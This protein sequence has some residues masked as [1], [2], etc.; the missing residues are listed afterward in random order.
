M[1][2]LKIIFFIWFAGGFVSI[3]LILIKLALRWLNRFL[4]GE[5]YYLHNLKK[6]HLYQ[7]PYDGKISHTQHDWTSYLIILGM[8]FL[9]SWIDVI[10]HLYQIAILLITPIKTLF[11]S[12]PPKFKEIRFSLWNVPDLSPELVW[13]KV[14]ALSMVATGIKPKANQVIEDLNKFYDE[15][16]D[17]DRI[18]AF[19]ALN[20]TIELKEETIKECREYLEKEKQLDMEDEESLAR[21]QNNSEENNIYAVK[22]S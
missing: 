19:E 8:E 7:S 3:G 1:E 11:S 14:Y 6:I 18:E 21:F 20:D 22:N 16:E 5:K 4:V 10:P 17:F 15:I 13:S 12:E 2:T 9:F